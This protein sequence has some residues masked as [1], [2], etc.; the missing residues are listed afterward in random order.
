MRSCPFGNPRSEASDK[1]LWDAAVSYLLTAWLGYDFM[2]A[3]NPLKGFA[4]VIGIGTVYDVYTMLTGFI[5]CRVDLFIAAAFLQA[6]FITSFIRLGPPGPLA[7]RVSVITRGITNGKRT[8]RGQSACPFR[9]R[10][11]DRR[12]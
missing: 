11:S 1:T 2:G 6:M 3:I 8:A 5:E 10:G 4:V 12:V 9:F 7:S